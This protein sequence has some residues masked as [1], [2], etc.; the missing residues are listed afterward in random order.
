MYHGGRATHA[1]LNGGLEP[2]APSSVAIRGET[3]YALGGINFTA[4]KAMTLDDIKTTQNEFERSL[5]LAKHAN[6]D[7]I[8][9]Q[10]ATGTHT[11]QFLRSFSNNRTDKYGG[12]VEN[13][14]RFALELIDLALKTFKPYQIGIKISPTNRNNDQFDENPEETYSYLLRELEKRSVG[15]VEIVE[16]LEKDDNASAKFHI[17]GKQ[18]IEDNCKTL[19][20][21]FKGLIIANHGFNPETG[22]KKI[23]EGSC[24]A[25]SFARL[26]ITNP[27]LAVRIEKG[28]PLNTEYDFKTFYGVGLPDKEKG[29]TDYL[30]YVAA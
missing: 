16:T 7:G 24:D 27:D 17:P 19:R 23:Q 13:R 8:E 21:Y 28:A 2:W 15:F 9:L 26:H 6:F 30:P 3:I 18:Q 25:I 29:F 10:C 22:L 14:A 20:P 4:P 11:D 12:S 5:Q 1:D